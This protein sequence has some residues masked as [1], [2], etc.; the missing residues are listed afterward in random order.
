ML[1]VDRR[2]DVDAGVEQRHHVLV[3]L[4]VAAP[5]RVRVRQ[6]VH[7]GDG[8]ASGQHGAQVHLLQRDA[9]VF[10][11]AERDDLQPLHECLR[12]GAAV[13]LDVA[14]DD[15]DALLAERLGLLQ[16]PVRLADARP[17]A[18]VHLEPPALGSLDEA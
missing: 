9:P 7:G 11:L 18:Q 14:H 16:H 6:L 1:D 3:A 2:Q 5:G 10:L 8:R 4:A 15:I 12:L 17:V 13:V